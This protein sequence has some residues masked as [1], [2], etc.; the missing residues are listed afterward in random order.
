MFQLFTESRQL[1]LDTMH[2]IVISL[3][4]LFVFTSIAKANTYA[5]DADTVLR[6]H[7]G[8]V[9]KPREKF[10]PVVDSWLHTFAFSLPQ[11]TTVPQHQEFNCL[12]VSQENRSHCTHT[13]P[14]VDTLTKLQHN[15]ST[16][17]VNVMSDIDRIVPSRRPPSLR[18]RHT[19]SW[20][21]FL[22]DVLHTSYIHY[23]QQA[24][25]HRLR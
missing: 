3:S 5:R 20:I 11:Y 15:M 23:I 14:Y 12:H 13:K 2:C 19:R 1:Y 8:L 4:L 21:P 6:Q 9:F 24:Q 10:M 25:L 7:Y 18:Q 16:I 22:G 17:L